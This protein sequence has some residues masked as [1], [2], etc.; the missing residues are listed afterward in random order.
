MSA[1]HGKGQGQKRFE[2]SKQDHRSQG[3]PSLQTDQETEF[4]GELAY[5]PSL[6]EGFEERDVASL[7]GNRT[8]G[9]ISLAMAIASLFVLPQWF[10][11]AGIV[12]GGAAFL[13]GSRG[14]AL[15]S[16]VIGAISLVTYFVLVPYYS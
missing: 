14:L 8:L 13:T 6:D 7:T 9:W 4:A 2:L 16:I 11:L 12:L 5:S 10:G 3:D 1:D 15:W